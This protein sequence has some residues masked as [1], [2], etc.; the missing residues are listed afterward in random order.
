MERERLGLGLSFFYFILN[1]PPLT[2]DVTCSV[3]LLG[4]KL[5]EEAISDEHPPLNT[6]VCF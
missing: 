4:R 2:R 1:W 5:Y 3:T 6:V